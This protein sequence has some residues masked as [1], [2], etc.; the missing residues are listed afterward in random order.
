MLTP[1]SSRAA[2]RRTFAQ[3]L[4]GLGAFLQRVHSLSTARED[5]RAPWAMPADTRT[6]TPASLHNGCEQ[7]KL[8]AGSLLKVRPTWARRQKAHFHS[9]RHPL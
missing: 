5:D 4:Y 7:L 2:R 9:G 6:L 8:V 1:V 3:R